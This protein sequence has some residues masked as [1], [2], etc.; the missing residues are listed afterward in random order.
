MIELLLENS[1]FIKIP[2]NFV[3]KGAVVETLSS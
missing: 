2:A 3:E 1:R